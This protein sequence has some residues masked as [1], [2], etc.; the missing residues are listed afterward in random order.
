MLL[1]LLNAAE[2]TACRQSRLVLGEALGEE[3]VPA[4]FV[5]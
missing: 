2:G 5:S 4:A 1:D 3:P